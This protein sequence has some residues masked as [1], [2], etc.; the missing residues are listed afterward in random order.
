MPTVPRRQS[1]CPACSADVEPACIGQQS[2]M[3]G[4]NVTSGAAPR[5]DSGSLQIDCAAESVLLHAVLSDSV[6]TCVHTGI[7][8]SRLEMP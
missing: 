7:Q 2:E 1:G 6:Q 3:R 8:G 5:K 4:C